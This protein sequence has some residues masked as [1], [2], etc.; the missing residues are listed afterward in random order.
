M[1]IDIAYPT[2]DLSLEEK[3][4]ADRFSYSTTDQIMEVSAAISF[5][6]DPIRV[7]S[8]EGERRSVRYFIERGLAHV[9]DA[10]A[11]DRRI[12]D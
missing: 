7:A 4:H 6:C 11:L 1:T 10:H 12:S 2:E 9:L 8:Q 5:P 3:Y